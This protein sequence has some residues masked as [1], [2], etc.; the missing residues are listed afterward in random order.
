MLTP[1][2]LTDQDFAFVDSD[3]VNVSVAQRTVRSSNGSASTLYD[4]M[5]T[6][7][8]YLNLHLALI[9]GFDEIEARVTDHADPRLGYFTDDKS[10]EGVSSSVTSFISRVRTTLTD[11]RKKSELANTRVKVS[12]Y[13][14]DQTVAGI[15]S[16]RINEENYELFLPN[17]DVAKNSWVETE[18]SSRVIDIS[19]ASRSAKKSFEEYSLHLSE[20]TKNSARRIPSNFL[21]SV[22]LDQI[23]ND[24]TASSPKIISESAKQKYKPCD[25]MVNIRS[26]SEQ[27]FLNLAA[28]RQYFLDLVFYRIKVPKLKSS[29]GFQNRTEFQNLCSRVKD[30][31]LTLTNGQFTAGKDSIRISNPNPFPMLYT[32]EQHSIINQAFTVTKVSSGRILPKSSTTVTGKVDF[33]NKSES[34]SYTLTGIR[35]LPVKNGSSRIMDCVS[36]PASRKISYESIKLEAFA[37]QSGD[38]VVVNTK[39]VPDFVDAV[40]IERK[41]KYSETYEILA[42]VQPNTPYVDQQIVEYTNY[43]YCIRFISGGCEVLEKITVPITVLEKKREILE[44]DFNVSLANSSANGSLITHTIQVDESRTTTVAGSLQG[45]IV[46]SGLSDKFDEERENNKSQISVTSRYKIT[47]VD[48]ETGAMVTIPT[49]YSPGPITVSFNGDPTHS[50]KYIVKLL[51]VNTASVSYLTVVQRE[52]VKTGSGYKFRYRKW[53]SSGIKRTESLPSQQQIVR[54]S[55][56]EG[57]EIGGVGEQKT[58]DVSPTIKRPEISDLT[59]QQDVVNRTNY[60]TWTVDG[61]TTEI[62]HFLVLGEYSGSERVIGTASRNKFDSESPYTY[63]DQRLANLLGEV[64][65]R[66]ILVE[67]GMQFKQPAGPVVISIDQSVP[68]RTLLRSNA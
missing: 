53:R 42:S 61:D 16:G 24:T 9:K 17:V 14:D 22:E 65:Y 43:I 60:L 13:L 15:G 46:S 23:L 26:L 62:D 34:R 25:I 48:L 58:L 7:R 66:V 41:E 2:L 35:D 49:L 5:Y 64:K 55:L 56:E 50:Y 1:E 51:A 20:I 68:E 37:E 3:F 21:P 29:F 52:D 57:V 6:M 19:S 63:G 38:T 28:K 8:V 33:G 59:V 31:T 32:L 27:Q 30:M 67:R 54:N 4:V 10:P 40:K 44:I 36:I 18:A 47:R 12:S 45:E 39:N 11:A